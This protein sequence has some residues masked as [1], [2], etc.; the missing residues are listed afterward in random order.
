MDFETALIIV[1]PPPVQAFSY[2]LREEF[3]QESFLNMPA[4]ITLISP[5]VPPDEVDATEKALRKLGQEFKPF[6]ITLD[7]YGRFEGV[8]FLEPADSTPVIALIKRLQSAFPEYPPYG[9]Q[10]DE[11]H[12]HLTLAKFVDPAI[13][14]AIELPPTPNFTFKVEKF[15]LYLGSVT[16]EAPFVPRLV[17]PLG[18]QK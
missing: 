8:I 18:K 11:I 6:E 5:F 16:D 17:I 10:F 13:G 12:P 15:H 9:G 4:H 1:P 14:E 3:D 7:Q 2:P